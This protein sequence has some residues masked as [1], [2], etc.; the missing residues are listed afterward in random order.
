VLSAAN[1]EVLQAG[2]SVSFQAQSSHQIGGRALHAQCNDGG[3]S[4]LQL[5]AAK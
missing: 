1:N 4:R 5:G 3:K 2:A